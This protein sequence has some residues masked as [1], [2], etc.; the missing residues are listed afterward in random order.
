MPEVRDF[1]VEGI[2]YRKIKANNTKGA[3]VQYVC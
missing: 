2:G 3:I 1:D